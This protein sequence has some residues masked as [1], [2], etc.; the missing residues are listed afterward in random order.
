MASSALDRLPPLATTGVGSLPF[1]DP[2]AGVRHA[3]R[4]YDVPFC[5]QLPALDGDMVGEWLGRRPAPL[6]LEPRPRPPAPRRLGC[7]RAL[8]ATQPPGPPARQ[9]PGDRA[10]HA[11]RRARPRRRGA[12]RRDRAVARG[13][14]R[15]ADRAAP[16]ARARHAPGVVDEPGLAGQ[17]RH[18]I[19]V[20]DRLRDTGAAAWGL[21][22]CGPVP[23]ALVDAVD[24]DVV[25]FD[26]TRTPLEPHARRALRRLLR[27][28]GRV[29][30][31]ALD[32]VDP[33]T[34]A[35]AAGLVAAALHALTGDGLE[36]RGGGGAQPAHAR[37]RD[38]PV[39][40]GRGA[41]PRRRARR[42]RGRA[43]RRGARGPRR[44]CF[45]AASL[46]SRRTAL[47]V[48]C[49]VG[50]VL[51]LVLG[52]HDDERAAEPAQH[53]DEDADAE[54]LEEHG[55]SFNQPSCSTRSG[56]ATLVV[57]SVA[58][59]AADSSVAPTRVLPRSRPGAGTGS[60]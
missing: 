17:G 47:A 13:E 44:A 57:V 24:A 7:V 11:R 3:A 10:R 56:S 42:G 34:S 22:V 41:A 21:H 45:H 19:G 40:S 27:R 58:A 33:G 48:R 31:G 2:A 1:E 5:P 35:D 55:E 32:P 8:A 6:R 49:R 28:G 50:V 60:S 52:A 14:R 59:S 30:W 29:A 36:R 26:L 4:A 25:S 18:G 51:R 53:L 46:T 37:V 23:W 38:R 9:A 15:G 20:W 12:R 54:Q 43:A 16:R 39:D